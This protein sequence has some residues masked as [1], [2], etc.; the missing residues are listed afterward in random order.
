MSAL[1]TLSTLSGGRAAIRIC[2]DDDASR[3]MNLDIASLRALEEASAQCRALLAGEKPVI[4]ENCTAEPDVRSSPSTLVRAVPRF[5]LS[6]RP[7]VIKEQIDA[8]RGLGVNE[9]ILA[10]PRKATA[11]REEVILRSNASAR[12][13]LAPSGMS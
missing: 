4:G 12:S 7:E 9:I 6:G 2:V 3:A 5:A 8:L 1:T 11:S 13:H 10:V